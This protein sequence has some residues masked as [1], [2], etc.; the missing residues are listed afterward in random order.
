MNL[1]QA[2]AVAKLARETPKQAP[3]AT[4]DAARV[5]E[6]VFEL[7]AAVGRPYEGTQPKDWANF[8][9]ASKRF[10]LAEVA[11]Y[12]A[13]IPFANRVDKN[14]VEMI[15][16]ASADNR[17]EPIVIDINKQ[18]IGKK[19]M[20]GYVPSVIV[21]DGKNRHRAQVMQGKDRIRA[22]VGE[23][24]LAI[25][26]ARANKQKF[27]V[28]AAAITSQPLS[29]LESIASLYGAVAPAMPRP[30]SG[31][32]TRQDTGDGGSRPTGGTMKS[33]G[34]GGGMGGP[35]ASGSLGGGAERIRYARSLFTGGKIKSVN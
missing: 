11:P 13:A 8:W 10:V 27:V 5:A 23:Q 29:K 25:L 6:R 15:I 21:V 20:T 12:E 34:G 28:Q 14:K 24:A 16:Q 30:T 19:T 3:A 22:W 26:Q 18:Q 17:I 7:A 4:L 2:T 33:M 35:G 1:T 31:S 32:I 9:L